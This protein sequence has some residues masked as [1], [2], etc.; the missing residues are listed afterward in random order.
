[1]KIIAFSRVGWLSRALAFRSLYEYPWGKMRDYSQSSLG[2]IWEISARFPRWEKA[3]DPREAFWTLAPNSRNKE[4][5][6]GKPV[7]TRVLNFRLVHAKPSAWLFRPARL[8]TCETSA[9]PDTDL[10]IRVRGGGG[11]SSRSLDK[12]EGPVSKKF[13]STFGP[14][15]GLKIRGEGGALPWTRHWL[16]EREISSPLKVC[17]IMAYHPYSYYIY[18][19]KHSVPQINFIS[20]ITWVNRRSS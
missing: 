8:Y 13:F 4:N 16:S 1:M 20:C 10:E 2:L 3:R 6:V 12:G 15:F 14:Q 19:Q 5:I 18:E 7:N 11:R 17:S 9:M